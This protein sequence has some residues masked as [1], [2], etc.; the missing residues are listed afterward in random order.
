MSVRLLRLQL[1]ETPHRSALKA[2]LTPIR[3]RESPRHP[4]LCLRLLGAV[5]E[6]RYCVH[7]CAALPAPTLPLSR[8]S[9]IG[10]AAVQLADH[11]CEMTRYAQTLEE[12][13]LFSFG[14]TTRLTVSTGRVV[15]CSDTPTH[16]PD[17]MG[18]SPLREGLEDDIAIQS[19]PG[20]VKLAALPRNPPTSSMSTRWWAGPSSGAS[21]MPSTAGA[22]LAGPRD[23]PGLDLLH[24]RL[25]LPGRRVPGCHPHLTPSGMRLNFSEAAQEPDHR[26]RSRPSRPS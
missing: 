24:P 2:A 8:W 11:A 5:H 19:P 25:V 14:I 16:Q 18:L 15:A 26:P 9:A 4:R 7:R 12:S 3:T 10:C 22:G 13:G 6:G 21:G 17:D 1:Q 23:R 20:A